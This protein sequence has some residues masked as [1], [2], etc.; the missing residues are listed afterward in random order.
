MLPANTPAPSRRHLRFTLA[1]EQTNFALRLFQAA[2]D[3]APA[4]LA[5]IVMRDLPPEGSVDAS[6]HLKR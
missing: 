3:D 6:F 2:N 5:T 4:P 1:A